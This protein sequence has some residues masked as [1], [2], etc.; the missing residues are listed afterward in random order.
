[1]T[2]GD[3]F[4]VAEPATPPP[5]V[6]AGPWVPHLDVL[7]HASAVVTQGGTTGTTRA[8]SPGVPVAVPQGGE[9][10]VDAD[11][12]GESGCGTILPLGRLTAGTLRPVFVSVRADDG[13]HRAGHHIAAAGDAT[14]VAD[15][16]EARLAGT[17][18]PAGAPGSAA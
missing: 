15:V 6:G 17:A 9:N 8:L 5:N 18:A 1:M 7:A 12:P 3:K 13:V 10:A 14:R 11:R 4:D 16:L 2:T